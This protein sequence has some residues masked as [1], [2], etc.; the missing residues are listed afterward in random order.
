MTVAEL[1]EQL[2]QQEPDALVSLSIRDP[3]DSAFTKAEIAVKKEDD[4]VVTVS[5]WVAS[6]DEDAFAP[7]Q[8]E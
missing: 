5:G 8:K 2:K 7:W 4:N 6:D 3:K 1:I